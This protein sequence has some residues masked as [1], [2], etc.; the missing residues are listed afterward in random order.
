MR[1]VNETIGNSFKLLDG[2]AAE[3]SGGLLLCLPEANAQAFIDEIQAL[4]GKPAWIVG[5]V[6]T[7]SND[8]RIVP[9]FKV[10]EVT[11]DM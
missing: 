5:R 9:D 3:T 2:L 7:G 10:I 6:V 1:K 11:P 8:A 4:D